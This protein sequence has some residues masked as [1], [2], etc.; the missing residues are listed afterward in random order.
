V[1]A[2]S[3]SSAWK[4]H[5]NQNLNR[6]LNL[7][8]RESGAVVI[9]HSIPHT[10]HPMVIQ[11]RVGGDKD[12][13]LTVMVGGAIYRLASGTM[14]GKDLIMADSTRYFAHLC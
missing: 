7:N 9:P 8:P 2:S 1:F 3:F 12:Q 4:P 6:N 13:V 14:Q 10:I 5:Q 11:N